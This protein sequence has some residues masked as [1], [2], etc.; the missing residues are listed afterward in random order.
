MA[1][2]YFPQLLP[3]IGADRD[4]W[5]IEYQPKERIAF[6]YFIHRNAPDGDVSE[7]DT[8]APTAPELV[9]QREVRTKITVN[10]QIFRCVSANEL[11]S[12]HRPIALARIPAST[13]AER[14]DIVVGV[15]HEASL[16]A[17]YLK[18]G[19]V[20]YPPPVLSA[21]ERAAALSNSPGFG[22]HSAVFQHWL[23]EN[24]LHR[25]P[26]E[27]PIMFGRRACKFIQ[28]HMVIA[29]RIVNGRTEF[30]TVPTWDEPLDLA[31]K[32]L[33]GGCGAHARL[34]TGILRANSIPAHLWSDIG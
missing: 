33:Y 17:R 30:I 16:F 23:D 34:Y 22:Y 24:G 26:D 21:S 9:E 6:S 19:P 32:R 20:T 11:S 29:T 3:A 12:Y 4:N 13:P 2:W 8:I 1:F 18:P 15:T 28:D 31:C 14:K 5:H 7:Y 25:R 27:T 10:G